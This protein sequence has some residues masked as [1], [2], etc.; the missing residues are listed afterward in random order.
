M[1][2]LKATN[3]PNDYDH[4]MQLRKDSKS[5]FKTKAFEYFRLVKSLGESVI[6]TDHGN[7]TIEVRPF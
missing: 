3:F 6:V 1:P 7:P 5:E 2:I 4:I